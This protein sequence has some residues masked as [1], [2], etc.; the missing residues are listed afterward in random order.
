MKTPAQIRTERLLNI[1]AC[2]YDT[3]RGQ[4]A[5]EWYYS[6]EGAKRHDLLLPQNRSLDIGKRIAQSPS[7]YDSHAGRNP[8]DLY[9]VE[10]EEAI[11]R[12]FYY[13][14]LHGDKTIDAKRDAFDELEKE[15][16]LSAALNQ[17]AREI[18]V[19]ILQGDGAFS[20]EE[21]YILQKRRK[22]ERLLLDLASPER[23]PDKR[24][25][26]RDLEIEW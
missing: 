17:I 3:L 26:N 22:R 2:E 23:A 25:T 20:Q 4:V 7:V 6:P 18:K 13:F 5:W 9:A 12:M 11:S 19:D 10:I 24:T 1:I 14:P 15:M 16:R 21:L 8:Y